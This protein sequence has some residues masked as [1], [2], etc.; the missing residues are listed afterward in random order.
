MT[1]RF[2]SAED[3]RLATAV[4]RDLKLAPFLIPI[5][6]R[7]GFV[8]AEAARD[9][10][11]PRLKGLA[12]PFSLP[13]IEPAVTRILQAVD[14]GEKIVLYGDYDV[15]GVTSVALLT[16]V[17]RAYGTEPGRFLPHRIEEGYGLTREGLERCLRQHRPRLLIALDC[18]TSSADQIGELEADGVN[19]IVLDHHETKHT[20]PACTAFINPKAG[21]SFHYLCT[22]G[23]V[24][25]L[26]HAL[27]KR[28]RLPGL[29]L[30]EFLDLV[31]VGTVAD[32][33]PLV[34]ENRTLVTFG[35]RQLARTRWVGLR[36]LMQVAAVSPPVRPVHVGYRLGPRLNAAGRLGVALDALN[37]LLSDDEGE[38]D[39]LARKLD[40]QNRD[41]QQ[42]EEATLREAVQL[43]LAD[44]EALAH[45]AIVVGAKGWHPGVVG[46]V[47]SRLMRRFHRPALVISF[48]AEGTGK[49][50]GRSIAGFSLVR[51][52]EQC[53]PF[54]TAYGGH[55]MAAGLSLPFDRLQTFR[56]AFLAV[57]RRYLD[58][59]RLGP[60]LDVTASMEGHD[61]DGALWDAHELLQPFGMGNPQ[62]LLCFRKVQPVGEPR[63]LK[64]KHRLLTLRHRQQFLRAIQ[65]NS[66]EHVLPPPPWDVAFHLEANQYLGRLE[67]Q[68]QVEAIRSAVDDG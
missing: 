28:R 2:Y 51:S 13:G 58:P 38:A 67:P 4:V 22:V 33:V 43:V 19:V 8:D 9:F 1:W 42:V 32:L 35:L 3:L 40:A 62:P 5:L 6:A 17:L 60:V 66:A 49:G 27:L 31:A 53:A 46:I 48:D 44:P 65:F 63:L 47:A 18:G 57:S 41:R 55:E 34:E 36:A 16:R 56:E 26:C 7:A 39:V 12:D 61:L 24:F 59:A 30:R 54:L 68:V 23:I 50:S 15:D 14:R 64:E 25:K 45:P 52:L 29:D 10:L 37:L 20:Q 21:H 11:Y